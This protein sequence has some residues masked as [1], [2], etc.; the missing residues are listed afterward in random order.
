M[1]PQYQPISSEIGRGASA[2]EAF[3][4]ATPTMTYDGGADSL[5][6]QLSAAQQNSPIHHPAMPALQHMPAPRIAGHQQQVDWTARIAEV[7]QDQ[8][9]LKPKVQTY[10]YKTPY[11][12]AYD[13]LSFPH[14]YKVP[15]F[16]KFSGTDDTSTVEHINRFI[17][18]CGETATQDALRVRLFS[19][20]LS[21]SA[22]QWFT[23]LPPNSIVTWADLEKQFHKYFYAGVHEMKLS[24]LTSL[25]QRSD[26]PVM[27]YIQRFREVRNKCYSLALTDAQLADIAFQGLLPQIKER[28]AAQ[29]FESLSQIVHRLSGQEVRPFEQRRNFQKKVAYFEG[30]ESDGEEEIGLAEWVKG[31]KP[32]LCPFGKKEPETFGFDTS[33]ADKIFDLLLQEG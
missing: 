6:H 15:D 19:S 26:E 16:T 5:R 12:S 13:L 33:K 4:G 28:Y 27:G 3:R 17:I 25:R 31:K 9:G 11:P 21:G 14:R 22:F 20:S 1:V 7:I 29:E 32:I 18:Q 23:T 2:V 30:S 10:T 8:F 24:D